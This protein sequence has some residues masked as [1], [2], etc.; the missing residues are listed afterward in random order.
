[1]FEWFYIDDVDDNCCHPYSCEED[2]CLFHFFNFFQ[3]SYQKKKD[4]HLHIIITTS[5]LKFILKIPVTS[6][7]TS[8]QQ[9]KCFVFLLFNVKKWKKSKKKNFCLA[10]NPLAFIQ[11]QRI[12]IWKKIRKKKLFHF[13]LILFWFWIFNL[14]ITTM[15]FL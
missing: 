11:N 5:G 15:K 7:L 1:L 14:T 6:T 8:W 13:I 3:Q 12:F 4:Y 2:L 10:Q 9:R